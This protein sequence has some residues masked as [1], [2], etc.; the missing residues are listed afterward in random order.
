MFRS[1]VNAS[2]I[3]QTIA[4]CCHGTLLKAFEY[5]TSAVVGPLPLRKDAGAPVIVFFLL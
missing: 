3:N 5:G 4:T 2:E 1:S